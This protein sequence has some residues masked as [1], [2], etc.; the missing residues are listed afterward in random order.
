MIC[1]YCGKRDYVADSLGSTVAL[2]DN[3]QTITDTFT[4]WPY[5]E[6]KT[7]TGT[8]A[9]PFQFVGTAGYYRDSAGRSYVRARHLRTDLTRWQTQDPIQSG[10]NWYQYCGS[11]P[12][13][14]IDPTG[15][16]QESSISIIV[17][18]L[19]ALAR[20]PSLINAKFDPRTETGFGTLEPRMQERA[21]QFL[22][23][24][25]LGTDYDFRITSATR[26]YEQQV[27]LYR[28]GQSEDGSIVT[29]ARGGQS[30]HNFG[31]A[32]DLTLFIKGSPA[33]ESPAYDTIGHLAKG[34][35]LEW[36]GNWTSIVDR[37]HYQWPTGLS[38]EQLRQFK[39]LGWSVTDPPF[40]NY[41]G[42]Q[43]L[44]PWFLTK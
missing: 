11:G 7:R 15:Y 19:L 39:N 35:G 41:G 13:M 38:L 22:L 14:W 26:T 16:A 40:L 44:P 36:G 28:Q 43:I 21:R 18:F 37:P 25:K 1:I 23:L 27:A 33:Y 42:I 17:R 29:R 32:F 5:G 12:V 2:L 10:G 30:K 20:D 31:I 24:V 3:T 34:V 8:T 9:T 4:Y 6:V